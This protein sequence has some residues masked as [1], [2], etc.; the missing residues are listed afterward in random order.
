MTFR[1]I[2]A[3][4]LLFGCNTP[5]LVSLPEKAGEPSTSE[6]CDQTE[7]VVVSCP[8]PVIN[9]IIPPANVEVSCPEPVI[10]N[11]VAPAN[12]E[13]SCPEPVINAPVN[14]QI[15][16]AQIGG[17]SGRSRAV[18]YIASYGYIGGSDAIRK[19]EDGIYDQNSDSCVRPGPRSNT[20]D[21]RDCCPPG[22]TP[23][24]FD[25]RS[26][27]YVGVKNLICLED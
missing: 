22:F 16:P 23:V 8:E 2:I 17:G 3:L 9:N 14:V 4:S 20:W 5:A 27:V 21:Y 7:N 19:M 12:V 24:G 11:N 18:L 1:S 10:N 15:D 26:S 25:D 13:V 6:S